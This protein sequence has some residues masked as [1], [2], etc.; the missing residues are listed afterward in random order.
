MTMC[1]YAVWSSQAMSQSRQSKCRPNTSN[2]T[3]V[4]CIPCV[5]IDVSI[6]ETWSYSCVVLHCQVYKQWCR[7]CWK[8]SSGRF[9]SHILCDKRS[10]KSVSNKDR[11]TKCVMRF[12]HVKY[13]ITL[14]Q[15]YLLWSLELSPYH[16]TCD[17]LK[18][19]VLL[20]R[21]VWFLAILCD[22]NVMS[23]WSLVNLPCLISW[24]V[25]FW[26]DMRCTEMQS[27]A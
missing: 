10:T 12:T 25:A 9:V 2:V 23:T 16:E 26:W 27:L 4:L 11:S 19:K 8:A 5:T 22:T 3:S 7:Q 17:A 6:A 15:T 1:K 20:S 18:Y 24:T 13:I 14:L 21:L